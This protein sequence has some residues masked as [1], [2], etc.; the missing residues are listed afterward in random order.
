M[1]S[2]RE[3]GGLARDEPP[4]AHTH[5]SLEREPLHQKLVEIDGDP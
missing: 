2:A 1:D 3:A 4:W 5:S